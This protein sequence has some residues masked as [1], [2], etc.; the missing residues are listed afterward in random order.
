[1]L[2]NSTWAKVIASVNLVLISLYFSFV[3]EFARSFDSFN[4][5]VKSLM[6]FAFAVSSWVFLCFNNSSLVLKVFILSLNSLKV[7]PS[8]SN[9][10]LYWLTNDKYSPLMVEYWGEISSLSKLLLVW[11]SLDSSFFASSGFQY[12]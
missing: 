7:T 10:F 11:I 5:L 4:K 9:S 6:L 1:M 12:F 2:L 8:F 3:N